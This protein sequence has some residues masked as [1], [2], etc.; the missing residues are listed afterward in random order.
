M[1]FE[2]Q[3]VRIAHSREDFALA[4]D[5]RILTQRRKGAKSQRVLS[6]LATLRLCDFA[7]KEFLIREI[8][9]SSPLAAARRAGPSV[10]FRG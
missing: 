1:F 8:R 3:S 9:G 5:K 10:P 2:L 7:L 4:E 6:V